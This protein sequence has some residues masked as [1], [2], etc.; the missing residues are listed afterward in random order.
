MVFAAG[1]LLLAAPAFAQ[2]TITWTSHDTGIDPTNNTTWSNTANWSG[3]VVPVDGDTLRF[4]TPAANGSRAMTNDLTNLVVGG[5]E[6]PANAY[7]IAGNALNL[8]GDI[9]F[10]AGGNSTF[11]INVPVTLQKNVTIFN[12]KTT[13]STP[14]LSIGADLAGPFGLIIDSSG[15]GGQTALNAN[16]TYTGDTT[17]TNGSLYLR[18]GVMTASPVGNL[19]IDTNGSVLS[20]N[21]TFS[22]GGLNGSG[23]LSKQGNNTRTA[24]LGANNANG[25]YSGTISW[26]GGSSSITKTG[27]GTQ[28]FSG[29]VTVSGS[30]VV[31]G[32]RLNIDSTWSAGMIVN[33]AGTLG[34]TGTL[35]GAV[36]GAGTVSPGA[37]VTIGTLAA[38]SGTL[39]GT[40]LIELD[41]TGSGTSDRFNVTTG[42][43]D[44]GSATLNFSELTPVDDQAYIFASYGSLVGTFANI[45][46]IP[47]N[48]AVDYSYQGNNIALTAV[49]EPGILAGLGAGIAGLTAVALRR[50]RN[51]AA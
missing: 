1:F 10:T 48:Y 44:I 18:L 4:P 13:S 25:S 38:G 46:N 35:S 32:G 2:S 51:A 7:T 3:G 50:R 37:A 29:P 23:P 34:G 39:T 45:T 20:N 24:T 14:V 30:G 40:L 33:A 9:N 5:F 31:N 12:E 41:G 6:V 27:T 15:T 16:V 28:T 36:T 43:L 42:A 49:P 19:T 47:T 26:I 21:L 8:N 22:V 17:V 11:G